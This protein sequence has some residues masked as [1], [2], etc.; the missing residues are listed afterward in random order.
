MESLQ[1]QLS[2]R[3]KAINELV[4]INEILNKHVDKSY[5]QKYY[6]INKIPYSLFH[7][8]P[9]YLHVG[10]SRKGVYQEDDLLDA[11]RLVERYIGALK[12]GKVLELA[13]GRGANSFFLATRYPHIKFFG[14]DYS[15]TQIKFAQR[16]KNLPHNFFVERSD[17]HN[18]H[19]YSDE[20]F[21][22]VFIVEA[23]CHSYDKKVVF[24][25]VK[26]I[27]RRNGVFIVYDGYRLRSETECASEE[28]L[29]RRLAERGMALDELDWYGNVIKQMQSFFV[30]EFDEDVS[31]Y[32]IPTLEHLEAHALRL[33][34]FPIFARLCF[35]LFPREVMCNF[36]TAYLL[37]LGI[38]L[39]LFSY[40]IT[41]LKR[42]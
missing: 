25:E 30:K 4:D 27:L 39:K 15:S 20:S 1:S 17:F 3:L 41:V 13:C 19:Q 12:A 26:R 24:S 40:H 42:T 23:L 7:V 8:S 11:V 10:I 32:T 2:R 31:I 38:K 5:I 6:R 29:A 22:I 28:K 21:D 34:R 18:L 9:E 14:V 35:K 37:S 16:K 33:M 36:I